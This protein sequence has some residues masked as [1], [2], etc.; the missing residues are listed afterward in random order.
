MMPRWWLACDYEPLA[1][2]E[3][4]LAWELRG[5]GVQAKTE[6]SLVGKTDRTPPPASRI[7][8]RCSGP[9]R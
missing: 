5:N 4:G 9:S 1:R 7:P 3:D 6:D 2:S 8:W